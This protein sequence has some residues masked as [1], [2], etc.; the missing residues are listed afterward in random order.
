M[1]NVLFKEKQRYTDKVNLTILGLIVLGAFI[2]A[3]NALIQPEKNYAIAIFLFVTT[4]SFSLLIWWLTKLK[5]KVVINDKYIQ[6]K[7]SPIHG[8][9]RTI[10]W[11]D[12]DKCDII[13]TPPAAQWSGGNIT[14]NH[15][16]RISLTGR[17][18]LAIRT[19]KGEHYFIGC[20]NIEELR[21]ALEE[22]DLS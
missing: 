16:K 5:L 17:N 4:L 11:E 19:K 12:I 10:P 6:F 1:K 2:G 18:G 20:K 22:I 8:K 13:K 9:K 14:Y 21:K 15:E 3:I 7:L